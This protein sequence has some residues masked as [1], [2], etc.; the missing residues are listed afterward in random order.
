L[1]A[2]APRCG[3]RFRCRG[4]C[5]SPRLLPLPL[6]S[7]TFPSAS[8]S[9]P[10]F[11]SSSSSAL[12]WGGFGASSPLQTSGRIDTAARIPEGRQRIPR[13]RA[14]TQH[15]ALPPLSRFSCR[16]M[17]RWTLLLY[18]YR[19]SLLWHPTQFCVEGH[20]FYPF[21]TTALPLFLPLL[22]RPLLRLFIR[23]CFG[24]WGWLVGWCLLS[25]PTFRSHRCGSAHPP[26]T[27]D[28]APVPRP[29]AKYT[30]PCSPHRSRLQ[31][32]LLRVFPPLSPFL[33]PP[34][35]ARLNLSND[36]TASSSLRQSIQVPYGIR[37]SFA[38][39]NVLP[40]TRCYLKLPCHSDCLASQMLCPPYC[41]GRDLNV[42]HTA[43][44]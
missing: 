19:L 38:L 1:T 34:L 4:P 37:V 17:I 11:S 20:A 2:P 25:S 43:S 39:R 26:T 36:Q 44:P 12:S 30:A 13:C 15:A 14:H 5:H 22:P 33:L 40:S 7:A 32:S 27:V 31:S 24:V 16:M 21:A 9:P 41:S 6:R 35:R 23:P 18:G 42:L 10:P 3:W 8:P 29:H 28:G